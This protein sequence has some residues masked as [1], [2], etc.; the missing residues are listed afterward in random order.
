MLYIASIPFNR[1]LL[2]DVPKN[3]PLPP[4]DGQPSNRLEPIGKEAK[5]KKKKKSKRREGDG[6]E[7]NRNSQETGEC[8]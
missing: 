1:S 5:K 8:F 6:N 7:S 3:R 4:I 2:A